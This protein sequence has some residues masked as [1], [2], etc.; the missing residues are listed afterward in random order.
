MSCKSSLYVLDIYP[1]SDTWFANIPFCRLPF[2]YWLYLLHRSF[3][4]WCSP[5]Y[6]FFFT[7]VVIF[8]KLLP[9][10][11]AMKIFLSVLFKTFVI[12]VFTFRSLIH[13]WINFC[14]WCGLWSNF[15]LHVDIQFSRYHLLRNHP[16]PL[17]GLDTLV[18]NQLTICVRVDFWAF[19]SIGLYVCSYA[20]TILF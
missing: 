19:Y 17:N 7:F 2:H 1:L 18:E 12:L 15:T 5:F 10:P 3:K 13:F 6:L 11:N 20:H 9:N 14:V 8:I 4:F 16:F